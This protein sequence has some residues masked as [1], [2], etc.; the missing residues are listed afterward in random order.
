MADNI[1]KIACPVLNEKLARDVGGNPR[2]EVLVAFEILYNP[3]GMIISN[4]RNIIC[5]EY[6]G[7]GL[8]KA[9]STGD[10]KCIYAKWES[11]EVTDSE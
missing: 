1:E 8:C 3:K 6:I 10:S 5:P 9:R 2:G 11:L 7:N 4:P